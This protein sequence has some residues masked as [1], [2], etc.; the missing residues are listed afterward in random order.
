[1]HRLAI[2]N[3]VFPWSYTENVKI[4]FR[5]FSIMTAI[6]VISKI[7]RQW[8]WLDCFRS[9]T[10]KSVRH[11][12]LQ[13]RMMLC[14]EKRFWA[15]L[16]GRKKL[17]HVSRILL[18]CVHSLNTADASEKHCFSDLICNSVKGSFLMWGSLL[19]T[20]K[21][22]IWSYLW[23]STG[24]FCLLGLFPPIITNF[25]SII[26]LT[27]DTVVNCNILNI[28]YFKKWGPKARKDRGGII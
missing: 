18:C 24:V 3:L 9:Y 23:E 26:R 16:Y 19:L 1:M 8:L 21:K 13:F 27:E 22:L 28:L 4:Y 17:L 2:M 14:S 20:E 7:C 12:S 15:Y 5:E 6:K 25:L 10:G 11:T